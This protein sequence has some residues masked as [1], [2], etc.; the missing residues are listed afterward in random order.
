ML[1]ADVGPAAVPEGLDLREPH[2]DEEC[3]AMV[4]VNS[5]AYG[6]DLSPGKPLLGVRS[7][8]HG[9]FP[10]IGR[11][12]GDAASTTAVFMVDGYRYVALVATA[13]GHQRRGYAD[14]TMRRALELAGAVH[15]ARPTV[16]HATDA[17]R[18]VYERMGYRTIANHTIFMSKA[19][20]EGH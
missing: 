7:F 16:L 4:D 2:D 11:A 18:P 10:V 6:M 8:W 5:L 3:G 1:A 17:G 14:A 12:G 19:L 13:P 9:H 20:L 15:G